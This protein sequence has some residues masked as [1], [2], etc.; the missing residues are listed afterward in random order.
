MNKDLNRLSYSMSAYGDIVLPSTTRKKI[1]AG[2][3]RFCAHGATMRQGGPFH[4][5]AQIQL[6]K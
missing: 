3:R 1:H 5:A 6:A 4:R 2:S